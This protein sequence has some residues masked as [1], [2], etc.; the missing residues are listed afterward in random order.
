LLGLAEAGFL[1]GMIFYLTHW[2]PSR[3]RARVFALFLTSTALAGVIGAP[4]SAALLKLGGLGGLHGWQWLVVVEGLPAV[5]LGVTT[6]LYLPDRP[7]DARWLTPAERTWIGATLDPER[8]AMQR[9][10]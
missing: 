3:E 6:L 2:I 1:P 7:A 4:L 8:V 10:H 5:A 9:T